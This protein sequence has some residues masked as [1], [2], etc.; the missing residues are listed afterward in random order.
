[1]AI[2]ISYARSCHL[3]QLP[4][5]A[6]AGEEAGDGDV[7]V[8]RLPVQAAGGEGDGRAL[9]GGRVEEA[10]KP[11]EGM[12]RTRPSVSVTHIASSSKR[13]LSAEM[14]MPPASRPARRSGR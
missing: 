13:T 3:P 12:P 2:Q 5:V 8:E 4:H 7:L 10:G 1:V 14:V 11:G 9:G 6:A